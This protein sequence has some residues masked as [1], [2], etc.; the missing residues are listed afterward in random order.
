MSKTEARSVDL[1]SS[2]T[3]S[4]CSG[5]GVEASLEETV[6]T[7][8]ASHSTRKSGGFMRRLG[9]KTSKRLLN[10]IFVTFER[11]AVALMRSVTVRSKSRFSRGKRLMSVDNAS[12]SVLDGNGIPL[13]L[14]CANVE[15]EG[16]LRMPIS[17]PTL[18]PDGRPGPRIPARGRRCSFRVEF[19]LSMFIAASNWAESSSV[20]MGSG[21]SRRYALK[22]EDT[23]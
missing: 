17:G 19:A 10:G 7:P 15:R 18:G 23:A 21:S 20:K 16:G 9:Q 5:W 2:T 3:D 6:H 14:G 11:A 12:S 4:S 8:S 22:T 1:I 13:K